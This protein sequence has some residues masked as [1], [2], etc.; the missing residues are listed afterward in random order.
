[1]S[2]AYVVNPSIHSIM[3]EC[4]FK[5]CKLGFRGLVVARL[6]KFEYKLSDI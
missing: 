1:M 4:K 6:Y 3:S 5:S 2:K